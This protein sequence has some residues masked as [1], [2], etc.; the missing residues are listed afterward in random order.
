MQTRSVSR[1]TRLQ[2]F[3]LAVFLCVFGALTATFAPLAHAQNTAFLSRTGAVLTNHNDYYYQGFSLSATTTFDLRYAPDYAS[4]CVILSPTYLNSFIAG[5][6]YRYFVGF[7]G[8]FGTKRFTLKPGNYYL[9]VRNEVDAQN[10]YSVELDY[11]LTSLAPDN[12]GSYTFGRWGISSSR[13]V[14]PNGGILYNSFS[15]TSAERLFLDGCNSGLET[16]IIAADQIGNVRKGRSFSY[17]TTYSGDDAALPGFYE[18]TLPVGSYYLVFINRSTIPK[19]VTY[20]MESW[21]RSN[22]LYLDLQAPASWTGSDDT[23]TIYVSK[24]LNTSST[25]TS[26]SLRLSLW[27]LQSPYNGSSN[28]GVNIANLD[29]GPLYPRYQYTNIRSTLGA[30][31]PY[32]TYY[33]AF[34]LSEWT[35]AAWRVVDW[36]NLSNRTIFATRSTRATVPSETSNIA[37]TGAPKPN[38]S[39]VATP[40]P[41]SRKTAALATRH[42][43]GLPNSI[44]SDDTVAA[45][46]TMGAVNSDSLI[47]RGRSGSK[48]DSPSFN[49][50][51]ASS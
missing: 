40:L 36:V 51:A 43:Q 45:P 23:V 9:A 37:A 18:L 11:A 2:T 35:G 41:A 38:S 47:G 17:Y 7:D 8:R 30:T 39:I 19:A 34:L 12:N 22:P 33:T 15:V 6:S 27:A 32:G 48:P 29:L 49:P 44:T 4:D 28:S 10:A 25:T 3:C 21:K 31:R 26:G 5:N 20:Q 24:I 1:R 16:Y 46:P 14:A 13:Y 42:A 50:S